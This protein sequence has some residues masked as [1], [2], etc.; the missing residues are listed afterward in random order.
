[1][2]IVKKICS[3][4]S[5]FA[6]ACLLIYILLRLCGISI[7]SHNVKAETNTEECSTRIRIVYAL[8]TES[9]TD[10][11]LQY[12]IGDNEELREMVNKKQE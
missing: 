9:F 5:D 2:E 11:E 4:V 3:A 12:I 1:M 6:F 8:K 7:N 10:E